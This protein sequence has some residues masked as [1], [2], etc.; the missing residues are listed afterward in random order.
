M[1]LVGIPHQAPQDPCDSYGDC[2]SNSVVYI[3]AN[4]NHSLYLGDSFSVPLSVT[5]GPN[6]TGY[7]V[8][9]S[10]DSLV[11]TKSGDTFTVAGNETGT[12]PIAESVTFTGSAFSS[13][14]TVSESVTII[15]LSIALQTRLVNVTDS[16]GFVERNLDGS[17]Y[18]NDTFC[19]SWTATFPFASARTDIRINVTSI[20]SPALRVL[21]YSA[22]PLGR[23]GRFCYVVE[24]SSAHKP[25]SVILV[26]RAIN[27]QGVSIALRDGSQPFAVVQYEP[28]FTAY[29]YMEFRNSTASSSLRRPWVLLVRYDGNDPGYSYVGDNNTLPFNGSATFE[30]RAYFDNFTFTSLSYQPSNIAGAFT[31]NVINSTGS[32]RCRWING[33][34]SAVL[35]GDRRIQKYVFEVEPSSLS[36]F[37][38]QGFVYQNVTMTGR[39]THEAGFAL[40]MNYWLVPFLWSG[41]VNVVSVGSSGQSLPDTLI[42]ITV[43]NPSPLDQWLTS[44]FVHVFGDDPQTLRA[45]QEDLYLTNQTMTFTGKGALSLLFNQTSL[46]PPRISITAGG[47]KQSGNFTFVPVLVNS[48]IMSAPDAFTGPVYYANATIPLWTYNM[49]QGSLA[50]LPVSTTMDQPTAFLELVNNGTSGWFAGNTTAPQTPSAFASQEYGFWPMGENLTVYANLQGGGVDLLGVQKA[51]PS[52]YQAT[53]SIEPWSGGIDSVQLVESGRT[54]EN[55]SSLNPSAYP[56][57]LPQGLTGLYELTYPATGQDVKAVFTNIWGTKT[58]ID[59]GT[60]GAAAP[61]FNLI[62][63]TTVAAFGIAGIAWLIV[64]G[65]LKTRKANV[66]Q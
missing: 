44:N 19:D 43:Q 63:E 40:K 46:V 64:S 16:H 35:E 45:F 59:L 20:P 36:P 3:R 14:L 62:P 61:S 29:S 2:V 9:W 53:F 50:F 66:H 27:W 17:F 23:T 11:F 21:N 54:I 55:I 28:Q 51:G 38:D 8:S 24:A 31:Y 22:D 13:T 34:G 32:L 42:S 10:Y 1:Y 33:G 41:R 49:F 6:T 60:A 4:P 57:P 52:E 25:Y 30:E 48:T 37:L 7:T 58:T 65:A 18:Y 26:A 47:V 15:Q 56:S 12:F 5:T 39:W